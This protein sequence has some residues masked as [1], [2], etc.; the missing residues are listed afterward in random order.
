LL[1][2]DLGQKPSDLTY[3][4]QLAVLAERLSRTEFPGALKKLGLSG[5]PNK[6]RN[7]APVAADVAKRLESLSLDRNERPTPHPPNARS[8]HSARAVLVGFLLR[9]LRVWRGRYRCNSC[10]IE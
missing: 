5:Q 3:S 9:T 6:V 2:L 10:G 1:K 7:D 4:G 8:R